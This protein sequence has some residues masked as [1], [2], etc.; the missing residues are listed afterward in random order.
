MAKSYFQRT[1]KVSRDARLL[2]WWDAWSESASS[3]DLGRIYNME[4]KRELAVRHY[5]QALE[6]QDAEP[7]TRRAAERG[8]EAP[9]GRHRSREQGGDSRNK[10]GSR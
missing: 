2:A 5:R 6:A 4:R 10:N 8:L 1:L 9:F 3:C 7:A